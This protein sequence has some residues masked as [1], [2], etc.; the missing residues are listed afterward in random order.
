M[1]KVS[2]CGPLCTSLFLPQWYKGSV[3]RTITCTKSSTDG[4]GPCMDH[5][6]QVTFVCIP[7]SPFLPTLWNLNCVWWNVQSTRLLG[8]DD[9]LD[10]F[11]QTSCLRRR[12]RLNWPYITRVLV[13]RRSIR[14]KCNLLK[15]VFS[16]MVI[17]LSSRGIHTIR[18]GG[19]YL[20][21]GYKITKELAG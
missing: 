7:L 14:R 5:I 20:L 6:R 9:V 12:L 16:K 10:F 19:L 11:P 2:P 3:L 8:T 1:S 18:C 13:K 21:R 15:V 17:K 4:S